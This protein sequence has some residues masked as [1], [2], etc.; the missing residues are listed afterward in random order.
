MIKQVSTFLHR[1][2]VYSVLAVLLFGML[3]GSITV[4]A[5]TNQAIDP[6][7]G[8]VSLTPSG[9][10]TVNSVALALKNQARDLSGAVLPNGSNVFSGQQL[11]FVL[12]VDNPTITAG[13]DL[14]VIDLL[15]EA[16]FTYLPNSLETTV[17]AAGSSNAAIWAGVWTPLTDVTGAPDDIASF[18]DS[19]DPA[20][21]DR[22]TIGAVPGQTNQ[23]LSLGAG[24]LRAIRFKVI[25]K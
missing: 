16:E 25:V 13:A 23:M 3:D 9:S 24:S 18:V 4:D 22:L 12:Y 6:G 5:A 17:V 7:G 20:G 19:G 14:Q 11:Y 21:A 8:G 2:T 15:N 1:W 10:V